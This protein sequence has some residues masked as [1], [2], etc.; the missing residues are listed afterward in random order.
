MNLI[1]QLLQLRLRIAKA[2]IAE[3][4][5]EETFPK[6]LIII[7]GRIVRFTRSSATLEMP[8]IRYRLEFFKLRNFIYDLRFYFCDF[9]IELSLLTCGRLLFFT[10][11]IED[12]NYSIE[13]ESSLIH[14]AIYFSISKIR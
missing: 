11:S 12:Y 8:A 5:K 10:H 13:I 4:I 14:L 6:F 1:L 7:S 2:G 9:I 3:L